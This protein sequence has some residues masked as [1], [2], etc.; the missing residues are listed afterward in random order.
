MRSLL[1]K[2]ASASAFNWAKRGSAS[3]AASVRS[4]SLATQSNASGLR[5]SSSQI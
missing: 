5:A 4:F 2:I 1:S 3:K